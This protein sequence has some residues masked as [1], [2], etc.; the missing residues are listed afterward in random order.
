MSKLYF[1]YGAMG[2][3][4]TADALMTT[5]NYTEKN[6]KALLLKPAIETRNGK[7]IIK[8][9]IGLSAKCQLLE[10]IDHINVT[11]YDVIIVDEIQFATEDQIDKLAAIADEKN[12][13]VICYGLRTDFQS[14][15]FKGTKRLMEL[16]DVIIEKKT[17]CWCGKKATHNARYNEHGIIRNG[18]LIQMGANESYISL[19]RKHFMQGILKKPE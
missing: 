1:Y 17:M 6:Q 4:K 12:I 14:H 15:L 8:S 2:S 5:F 18:N 11:D 9:R 10:N 7:E 13:P 19:C 16:A 3:S